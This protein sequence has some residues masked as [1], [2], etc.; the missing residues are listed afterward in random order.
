V[1]YELAESDFATAQNVVDAI[2]K[3][4]APGTA[5]A[6]DGRRIA[7]R[8]PEDMDARV[9][10]MGRIDNLEVKR[11]AGMAKVIHQSAYRFRGDDAE[12]DAGVLR[13][14]PWQFVG[15]G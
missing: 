10:F 7:V 11:V 14:R 1:Y 6:V 4:M 9:A 15:G 3:N 5:Q 2:N 8:A 12:S 13:C